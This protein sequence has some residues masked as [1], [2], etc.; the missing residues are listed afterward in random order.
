MIQ[1]VQ[2]NQSALEKRKKIQEQ[3]TKKDLLKTPT[4]TRLKRK[5]MERRL[6]EA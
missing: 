6:S 3:K 2:F 1:K 4:E 5:K